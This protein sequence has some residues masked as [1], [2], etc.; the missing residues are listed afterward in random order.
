MALAESTTRTL[1]LALDTINIKKQAIIFANTRRSAEKSAEELAKN[2]KDD[3]SLE[4]IEHKILNALSS[5]TKQCKRLA[6]C[7]K[8]GVAFHHSGLAPKQRG[9]VEDS[10]REGKIKVICSTPT[11]AYGLDLPAFRVILQNLKRYSSRGL[12]YIPV[13]EYLQMSGRAGR[14]KFDNLGESIAIATTE[15]QKQELTDIY[16]N[17][18]PEDIYS[19]LATEPALRA[20]ILSLI[21]TEFVQNKDELLNFFSKTFWAHHYG[22]MYQ[23][24]VIITRILNMLEMWDFINVEG[25]IDFDEDVPINASLLGKRVS[26]LYLDPLTANGIIVGLKKANKDTKTFAFL[27][28]I[29]HTLE[30]RPLLRVKKTEEELMEIV[31]TK[32]EGDLLQEFV[33][34]EYSEDKHSYLNSLKTALFFFNW[35]NEF[36]EE[37]LLEKF[38][39]RPGEI[40]VKLQISKWLIYSSVELAKIVGLKEII[41]PLMKLDARLKY[42]TKEELL[43]LLKLKG[44]G[45]VRARKMFNN[46]IKDLG[47]LKR[48]KFD[49][50]A[51]LI[52]NNIAINIKKQVGQDFSKMKVQKNKRKGQLSL[53]KYEKS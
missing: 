16:L 29:S 42:G 47:S 8:R 5:P 32:Y 43:S 44:I 53:K 18:E 31:I 39:V 25:D 49:I 48:A 4:E 21:A 3:F 10:F 23:L 46:N 22:D 30:L 1:E 34:Y 20:N 36:S 6:F 27:Q 2:L 28:L 17:G 11:L 40:S 35:I 14:P 9:I 33:D 19:K 37:K 26:Q 7:V 38:D 15:K 24:N 12:R 50:L 41:N 52:G 51:Q 45:R 13:L